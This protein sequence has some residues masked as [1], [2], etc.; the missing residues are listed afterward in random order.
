[1]PDYIRAAQQLRPD[2][3]ARVNVQDKM[4]TQRG[5]CYTSLP[6]SN[7]HHTAENWEKDGRESSARSW[8][9]TDGRW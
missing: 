7:H 3:R 2:S 8:T 9:I 4:Q 6:H 5:A 1:M